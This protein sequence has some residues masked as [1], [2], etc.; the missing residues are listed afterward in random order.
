[1]ET[2]EKFSISIVFSGRQDY[3]HRKERPV[4][5]LPLTPRPVT[6]TIDSDAPSNALDNLILD[7]SDMLSEDEPKFRFEGNRMNYSMTL[8]NLI[9]IEITRGDRK[10]ILEN[11]KAKDER[12]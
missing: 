5:L 3:S 8:R 11:P 4:Q 9:R 1:M 2:V 6:V 12:T 7:L 10:I